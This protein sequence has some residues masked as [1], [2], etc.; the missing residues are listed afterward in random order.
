[1]KKIHIQ[2][3]E[4]KWNEFVEFVRKKHGKVKGILWS[5]LEK[6]IDSYMRGS[7]YKPDEGTSYIQKYGVTPSKALRIVDAIGDAVLEE[8]KRGKTVKMRWIEDFIRVNI[9]PNP[10]VIEKY[11][12]YFREIYL[13]S[14]WDNQYIMPWTFHRKNRE[15]LWKSEDDYLEWLHKNGISDTWVRMKEKME[16]EKINEILNAEIAE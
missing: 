6:A 16:K 14:T 3:D 13:W 9:S 8:F 5:E 4:D 15:P 1:M 10:T 7:P 11:M 12:R 2:V